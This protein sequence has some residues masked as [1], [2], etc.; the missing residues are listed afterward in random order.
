VSDRAPEAVTPGHPVSRFAV[1]WLIR[2]VRALGPR[3]RRALASGVAHLAYVLG[4]RRRIT[5][6]NLRAAFP[7]KPEAERRRIAQ[8]AYRTMVTAVVDAVTSDMLA[9]RELSGAV[10]VADWKGLHGHLDRGE[11]VLLVSAHLGSWELFADVMSRR[12]VRLSAVVRPLKGAFNEWIVKNRQKAGV[13]LI[14]PRGAVRGMLKALKRGRAVVQLIDQALPSPGAVWVPFFGR[15]AST[16]PAVSLAALRS[17]APVYVTV[18]VLE[19]GQL[20][21]LVEGPIA[22]STQLP[23]AEALRAHTAELSRVLESLVR[24]Y[25]DQWLWLHRRWKGTPPQEG[26]AGED[27]PSGPIEPPALE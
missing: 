21:M 17:G 23:R 25:P 2:L 9:N 7:E 20:K 24:R 27:A 3:A 1:G 16:S 15:P 6:E 14:L 5:L 26:V 4:I 19:A 10:E 13:E 11:P 22:V 12:G 18:A 8:G